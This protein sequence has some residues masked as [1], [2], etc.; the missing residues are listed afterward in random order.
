MA[1]AD[2]HHGR[3]PERPAAS[4][5][6]AHDVDQQADEGQDVGM[7]LR[8]APAPR[9]ISRMTV[10]QADPIARVKVIGPL[11]VPAALSVDRELW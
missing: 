4:R 1:G 6:A 5:T 11:S 2:D 8:T 7:D 3:P 10:L 9:T